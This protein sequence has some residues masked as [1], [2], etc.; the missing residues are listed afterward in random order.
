M[1]ASSREH[2]YQNRYSTL[3]QQHSSVQYNTLH[4]TTVQYKA[5]I[6][7][8]IY[9]CYS[10][11]R[12]IDS[13]LISSSHIK[14]YT[15]CISSTQL[16]PLLLLLSTYHSTLQTSQWP[17]LLP[18]STLPSPWLTPPEA[19]TTSSLVPTP[20]RA[21]DPAPAQ[22][23]HPPAAGATK[24]DYPSFL[25]A[26]RFRHCTII[27]LLPSSFHCRALDLPSRAI[28]F[29]HTKPQKLQK[30]IYTTFGQKCMDRRIDK[31][32]KKTRTLSLFLSFTGRKLNMAGKNSLSSQP[33]G[34]EQK[35]PHL[36]R[37][38]GFPFPTSSCTFI[39]MA[40]DIYFSLMGGL[41]DSFSCFFPP[42][43]C[44]SSSCP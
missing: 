20:A 24:K 3:N 38:G 33:P 6:K 44:L 16:P 18:P 43:F 10:S 28:R 42:F 2:G 30:N 29:S 7:V 11:P 36:L 41:W 35:Q 39:K 1:A 27:F 5:T 19:A 8:Y 23:H 13:L 14:S 32:K 31:N 22:A 21:L 17:P 40:R 37:L 34:R 15:R 25:L 9:I 26:R 4:Y 12:Y